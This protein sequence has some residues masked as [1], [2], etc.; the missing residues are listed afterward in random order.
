MRT[1]FLLVWFCGFSLTASATAQTPNRII[2]EGEM[3]SLTNILLADYFR[4]Y[5]D[6]Y[7]SGP[8]STD[9]WRGY[10]ATFEVRDN[11]IFLSDIEIY[12][13]DGSRF[14]SVLKEVYPEGD[15][16]IDWFSGILTCP[17]GD[18]VQYVPGFTT[19]YE[20]YLLL[21]VK[22]GIVIGA[23]RKNYKE[24]RIPPG[25][26]YRENTATDTIRIRPRE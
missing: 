14:V 12:S 1:W 7:P 24:V 25:T 6:K 19:I 11:R 3:F 9:L 2:Y 21:R 22:E 20:N 23:E 8:F 26:G 5:P 17:Y 13:D 15:L 16:E 4:E 18:I 10:R